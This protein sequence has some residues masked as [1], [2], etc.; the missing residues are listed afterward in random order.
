[1][2]ERKKKRG[3]IMMYISKGTAAADSAQE[4]LTV[5]MRGTEHRLSEE[6][7]ALWLAGQFALNEITAEQIPALEQLAQLG[8][9]EITEE[10]GAP[11]RYR[12]LTGCIIVP[13][14]PKMF[15]RP[16]SKSERQ[17]WQ[18]IHKAGLRLTIAEIVCLAEK[19]VKPESALIGAE[20]RQ[21]LVEAIY[22]AETIADNILENLM[23]STEKRDE[24]VESVLGL[25]RKKRIFVI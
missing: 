9:A 4:N 19:G 8:L 18:W 7:A 25:L 5:S 6:C 15:H 1:M 17:T 23:E 14:K 16:L 24:M 12:L 3:C 20:N 10:T 21:N 22:S 11:G 2:V 13:A